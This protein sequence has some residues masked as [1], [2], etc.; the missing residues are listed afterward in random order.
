MSLVPSEIPKLQSAGLEVV[1]ES[2]AG[3]AAGYPDGDYLAVEGT[4][5]SSDV[6]GADI[7]VGVSPPSLEQIDRLGDGSTW[8]SFLPPATHLE[9]VGRLRDRGVNTFSFDLVPRTTRAQSMDALSSQANLAGYQAVLLGAER[10][11]RLFPMMMTAAGTVPPARVLVMGAGVA[12]LQA[13]ATARRLG[14][15]VSAYDV[16]PEVAEEVRSLGATL[17]G[18]GA[19]S[20]ARRG[21]LRR[22]A[23]RGFSGPPAGAHRRQRRQIRRGDHHCGGAG[24]AGAPAGERA[25]GRADARRFGHRRP[26]RCDPAAT[27]R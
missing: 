22:R 3:E 6:G 10:L 13:I 24:P 7:V 8:I 11:G 27:A 21:R 12:G 23:E 18:A 25:A 4:T 16:R 20:P 15:A 17:R 5:T 1:V 9:E 14:A 19:R 26:G 2:G